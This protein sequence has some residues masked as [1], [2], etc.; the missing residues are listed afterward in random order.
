MPREKRQ[1]ESVRESAPEPS[2]PLYTRRTTIGTV[3]YWRDDKGHG[4]IASEET[5]PWDIWC[6]FSA[7]ARI[8]GTAT[9][10]S[11]ESFEV[12][13]D[14]DGRAFS[15]TGEQVVSGTIQHAEPVNLRPGERVRVRYCRANQDSFK[16]IAQRVWRL[17]APDAGA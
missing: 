2:E 7:I 9:L 16:Y 8:G 11:G 13:Y 17:D 15:P 12:T 1:D 14:D 6:H 10:P 4:A 3:K 5:A